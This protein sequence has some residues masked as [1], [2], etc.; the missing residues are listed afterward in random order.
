MDK[1]DLRMLGKKCILIRKTTTLL[2]KERRRT[3]DKAN[4][5][6]KS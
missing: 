3:R 2:E 4:A 6:Y 5:G 1:I